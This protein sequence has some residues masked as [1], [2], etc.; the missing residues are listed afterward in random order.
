[1]LKYDVVGAHFCVHYRM[2]ARKNVKHTMIMP[3]P[4]KALEIPGQATDRPRILRPRTQNPGQASRTHARTQDKPQ[5]SQDP[6][7]QDSQDPKF[8]KIGSEFLETDLFLKIF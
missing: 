4:R 8:L 1:M 6:G 7:P 2:S 3:G 5:G